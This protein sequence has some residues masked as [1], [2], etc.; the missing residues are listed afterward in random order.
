MSLEDK[1]RNLEKTIKNLCKKMFNYN[2]SNRV[3]YENHVTRAR[4]YDDSYTV[5]PNNHV[6]N[7]IFSE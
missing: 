6:V 3:G 2:L 4:F 7:S 5:S 1:I